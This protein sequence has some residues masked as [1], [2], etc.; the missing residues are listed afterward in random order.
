MD[1][2]SLGKPRSLDS[3][4]LIEVEDEGMG[5]IDVSLE[6]EVEG[7]DDETQPEKIGDDQDDANVE[8]IIS[9]DTFMEIDEIVDEYGEKVDFAEEYL[10]ISNDAAQEPPAICLNTEEIGEAFD[11][12]FAFIIFQRREILDDYPSLSFNEMQAKADEHFTPFAKRQFFCPTI[13]DP[14]TRLPRA[15]TKDE[16]MTWA[17]GQ[18]GEGRLSSNSERHDGSE[19]LYNF[20]FLIASLREPGY[21]LFPHCSL[22]RIWTFA[23]RS[24]KVTN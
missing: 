6:P 16:Y 7:Q 10:S 22:A 18:A 3:E 24:S 23:M 9:D 5:E 1:Q 8:A 12:M 21:L 13:I 2:S 14:V 20:G 15:P 4:V 11:E 19:V 17:S